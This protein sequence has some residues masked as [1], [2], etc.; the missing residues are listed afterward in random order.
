M[1]VIRGGGGYPQNASVLVVLVKTHTDTR[2]RTRNAHT[3]MASS[4]KPAHYG[5]YRASLICQVHAHAKCYQEYYREHLYALTN[6]L[7]HM[8]IVYK[9][10]SSQFWGQYENMSNLNIHYP[11]I[12]IFLPRRNRVLLGHCIMRLSYI[13]LTCLVL[14]T[15]GD[16][17]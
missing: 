2:H 5:S 1:W 3:N 11:F 12:K 9:Y 16:I 15:G 10:R 14:K 8:M 4:K 13:G 6:T 7:K 17:D